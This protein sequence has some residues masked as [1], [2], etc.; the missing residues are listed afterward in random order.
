MHDHCCP[1]MAQRAAFSCTV[2]ADPF[3]CPDAVIWY[4]ARF[5]EFGLIVHDGGRSSVRIGYC[6]WCGALLPESRRD[7]WFDAC[8]AQGIDPW[9]DGAAPVLP[10]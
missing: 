6:P 7:A 1:A 4:S 2:H 10:D 5:R 3:A 8:E 9:Q